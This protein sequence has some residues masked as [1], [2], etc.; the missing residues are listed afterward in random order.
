M[1]NT[2]EQMDG[3]SE[4]KTF[5]NGPSFLYYPARGRMFCLEKMRTFGH[6]MWS[7]FSTT[8]SAPTEFSE[9]PAPS[10]SSEA[11]ITVELAPSG[12]YTGRPDLD[13]P[14]IL[15]R[16]VYLAFNQCKDEDYF[17]A[18]RK[19]V[20]HLIKEFGV[21][22]ID[23]QMILTLCVLVVTK[24]PGLNDGAS[25]YGVVCVLI[26]QPFYLD[27]LNQHLLFIDSGQIV[28]SGTAPQ[29]EHFVHEI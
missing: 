7:T 13:N 15:Q 4:M 9:S 11:T 29:K 17:V 21:D 25:Y 22:N 20:E 1:E 26:S 14:I 18:A 2:S 10:S 5:H 27:L 3:K 8:M 12:V 24:Y 19:V 23:S 6:F 28:P 16:P